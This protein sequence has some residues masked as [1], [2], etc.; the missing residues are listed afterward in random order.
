MRSKTS[1]R[2]DTI[3]R[4]N[5]IHKAYDE[6]MKNLGEYRFYVSKS[7]IYEEIKKRARLSH[8]TIAYVL[9]HTKYTELYE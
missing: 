8:K 9:N 5:S 3:L 6:V 4:D 7:Y 2:D 1:R